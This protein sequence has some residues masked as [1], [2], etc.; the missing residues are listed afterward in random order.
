MRTPRRKRTSDVFPRL[1][2]ALG[3]HDND[4]MPHQDKIATVML[5]VGVV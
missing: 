2:L 3:V 5:K 4:D 1:D